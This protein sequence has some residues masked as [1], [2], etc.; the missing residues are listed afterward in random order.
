MSKEKKISQSEIDGVQYR[1][2]KMWQIILV[3]CNAM[4]GMSVYSLIGMASYSAS[5]GYGVSTAV[6]GVILTCTRILDGITDPILAFIYDKVDTKF[7]RLRI[8]LFGGFAI[9]AIALLTMFDFC[10]SKGFG[11]VVFTLIY[12]VY[13]IGYTITNMTAQTLPA[14][15]SNDP[16]QRP[17]I[18][19]WQTAFN[20]MVPMVMTV[21]LNMVLLPKFGGT[22]NQNFLSAAV[23]FTIVVAAIGIVLVCIGISEYDK[24]EYYHGIKKQEPLKMKDMVDVLKGNKPLQAYIAAQA[25]DKIAQQTASQAVVTTMLFGIII[26]DMSMATM[27]SVISMLPSIVFAVFGAKYAGNH[28]SKNA[29]VTW[30]KVCM[31]IAVMMLVFFIVIDPGTISSFGVTMIVYVLFTLALNGA[32][33]CVT[34]ADTSFMADIIDYELDRSGR[35]VPAV[36]SGTYS[37]IDKLISSLSALLAT[38]AVALIGYTHTMPQPDEV[39]TTPIFVV[40]M[41]IY[42]GLPFIGWL[43]TLI[44]MKNCKLT[45]E[46]MVQVQKRIAS[47]KAELKEKA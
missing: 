6:V 2:A 24:P 8:L 38:G 47:K 7:G 19:V 5:I 26:G 25:S 15:M 14:I 45:R 27:L 22:Y 9:E 33:M 21:V 42:F 36:I 28:G 41:A 35:Y 31:V 4:V 40:T 12:V 20:Y 23:K 1:R 16:K 17:T 13:I 11:V 3:A 37:L 32:K 30:T 46:E 44:A 18:G 34:T 39:M 29:I 10:S 43:I